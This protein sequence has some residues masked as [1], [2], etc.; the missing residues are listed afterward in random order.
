MPSVTVTSATSTGVTGSEE[1]ALPDAT[2]DLQQQNTDLT[3]TSLATGTVAADG[4]F[5]LPASPPPGT[6][7]RVVV[8][9]AAG[10]GYVAGASEAQTVSG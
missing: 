7:V 2:V 3:W 1:P 4:T 5:T 8:T 6:A 10:S 9:P